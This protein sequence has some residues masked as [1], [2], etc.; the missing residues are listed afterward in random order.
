MPTN[1]SCSK[2]LGL[3]LLEVVAVVAI[4]AVLAAVAIPRVA[5]YRDSTNR[6]ACHAQ[7]G[8]IE[9]QVERWHTNTGSYPAADLSDI[10]A[11]SDYFPEG[12]PA[13]PVDGTT[14]TINTTSGLVNGH[15]H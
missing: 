10:G 7:R 4:L 8:E 11:D 3:S 9:L 12:V 13:C 6:N 1:W 15:D 14:Y 5:G 2:R